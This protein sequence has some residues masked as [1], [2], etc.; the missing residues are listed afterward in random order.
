MTCEGYA[1][2]SHCALSVCNLSVSVF[3]YK[4]SAP[5]HEQTEELS[6]VN[7]DWL[8]RRGIWLVLTGP[9]PC[10]LWLAPASSAPIPIRSRG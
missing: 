5:Q 8:V 9:K 10:R 1:V 4:I 2:G 7:T 3:K 6:G